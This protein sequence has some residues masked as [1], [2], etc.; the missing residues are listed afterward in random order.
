[1]PFPK[2]K[3]TEHPKATSLKRPLQEPFSHN[4]IG[5][6]LLLSGPRHQL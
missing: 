3:L 5:N 2:I 1:M 6:D 4:V